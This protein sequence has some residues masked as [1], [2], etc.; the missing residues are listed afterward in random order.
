[1]YFNL[2]KGFTV[3]DEGSMSSQNAGTHWRWMQHV[4]PKCWYSLTMDAAC[5]PKMLVL[6]E[7]GCSMSPQNAGTHWRWTQ[8]V[9]PIFWYSLTMNAACPPKMLVLTEDGRSMS[10]QNAGTHW[11]WMQELL[12]N[13]GTNWNSRIKV[14]PKHFYSST[15]LHASLFLEDRNL[16]AHC[17]DILRYHSIRNFIII[18]AVLFFWLSE[19]STPICKLNA[20][21]LVGPTIYFK[22]K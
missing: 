16:D 2:K 21:E 20:L 8:H 9:P 5:P 12:L 19:Y 1:L 7:D 15:E 18:W 22:Q 3:E 10:P 4:P 6:T 14:S 11:R 17:C 13:A